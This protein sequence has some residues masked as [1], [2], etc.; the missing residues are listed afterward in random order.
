MKRLLSLLCTLVLLA[1][2]CALAESEDF[3]FSTAADLLC[4]TQEKAGIMH[5]YSSSPQLLGT[6]AS[7]A[8]DLRGDVATVSVLRFD[9]TGAFARFAALSGAESIQALSVHLQK[10]L[11]ASVPAALITQ[12]QSTLG[13]NE[14]ATATM[15]N[16][17]SVEG[18]VHLNSDALVLLDF[19]ANYQLACLFTAADNAAVTYIARPV[20]KNAAVLDA[21]LSFY[22]L[23]EADVQVYTGDVLY[24]KS[25]NTAL[26]EY[27]CALQQSLL[28]AAANL[29]M[30]IERKEIL[31]YIDHAVLDLYQ[32]AALS[33][34]RLLPLTQD[35]LSTDAAAQIQLMFSARVLSYNAAAV[36]MEDALALSYFST[37]D[38]FAMPRSM[39][40]AAV[41][42]IE[43]D[44]NLDGETGT[45]SVVCVFTSTA[46]GSVLGTVHFVVNWPEVK[47][48]DA[49]TGGEL[50]LSINPAL[51]IELEP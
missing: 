38:C 40:D 30:G 26:K 17:G 50:A 48:M 43:Y 22:G 6:A 47:F 49:L 7:I 21:F 11:D 32:P 14:L 19:A 39:P 35:L 24:Q 31:P 1:F 8:Q 42:Q 10:E 29:P 34:V 41:V 15:M 23:S 46:Q 16:I 44:V 12:L 18:N 9:N 3:L 36:G 33:R 25:A 4:L 27:A 37:S 51:I 28:S 13:E 5:L 45:Y 2:P 20:H